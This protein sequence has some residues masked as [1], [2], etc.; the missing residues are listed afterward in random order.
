MQVCSHCERPRGDHPSAPEHQR[1]PPASGHPRP[2]W[3]PGVRLCFPVSC[4][5]PGGLSPRGGRGGRHLCEQGAAAQRERPGVCACWCELGVSPGW[6]GDSP[7]VR[8]LPPAA[9]KK[10]PS[11]PSGSP[12]ELHG[13]G[14]E[15]R[16]EPGPLVPSASL[17]PC[18]SAPFRAQAG[19]LRPPCLAG[20]RTPPGMKS[21]PGGRGDEALLR[22]CPALQCGKGF[23]A[24]C[25]P[26][27]RTRPTRSMP[28]GAPQS[29]P[30]QHTQPANTAPSCPPPSRLSP[31]PDPSPELPHF[32]PSGLDPWGRP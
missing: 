26:A 8:V 28:I 16:T 5:E 3:H 21:A 4:S 24:P 22:G 7:S 6:E 15:L 19:P 31:H 18:F 1:G 30:S 11:S 29:A 20:A 32:L 13:G 27:R 14:R 9:L 12:S 17:C 10:T 2:P 23:P 25:P